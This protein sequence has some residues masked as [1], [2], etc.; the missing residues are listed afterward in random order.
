M[1]KKISDGEMVIR[2]V[3][4]YLRVP[5]GAH[6][7]KPL[8]LL[9]FQKRFIREI[10]D[11][12]HGTRR[13]YMCI[14]RKN[15]KSALTAAIMLAH[16]IGPRAI[17]NSQIVCGAMSRDQA[18]LI[19]NLAVKMLRL[20]PELEGL[21]HVIPSKK[22]IIGMA[23]NV[24]FKALAS[25][26]TTAHGLSPVLAILDEVGQI[27][28]PSSPFVEAITTSQGAHAEPLLIA[29]STSAP[30]DG[31]MWSMW[32][33]DAERSS[34]PH[35]VAHVYKAAEGCDLMDEA[36]WRA[37][38]PALGTFLSEE[39]V[40]QTLSRAQRLPSEEASQ[41]N[42]LLN[43]RISMDRLAFSPSAWKA[44]AMPT[45]PEVFRGRTVYMGLDLSA[46]NDLTAAVLA[47]E[48]DD[49]V[50]QLL[51]IVFCP[52]SG[53]DDRGQRDR[54]PYR[55]WVDQGYLIPVGSATMDY[56][57][58]AQAIGDYL[59]REEIVVEEV[60]Y[61]KALITHFQAAC[62]RASVLQEARWIGVPQFFKEVGI[63]LASLQGLVL[64]K[65][66][67]HGGHPLLNY[68]VANAVAVQGR[69]GI[70]AL[71][72][73]KST[74]RI[75]PLAAAVFAAWPLGEGRAGAQFDVMAMI[76]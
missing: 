16:L 40:R 62:Q 51:P 71:D 1:A 48:D 29:L 17:H 55:M 13:A 61:D 20:N 68:A 39:F 60:H 56:D 57:Q 8:K 27:V 21:A 3:E 53:I 73:K 47:C 23:R 67:A 7:G 46:K 66:V 37:A 75:D 54:A 59:W 28:G 6:V 2:F 42:L 34:D 19:W 15:G 35:T 14:A 32:L 49:G 41:R 72:K 58:I 10:Y 18:S 43:Q 36:Q 12:P 45:G 52:T 50:I 38:N 65:R 69:E 44:C 25:D 24:E 33:D 30:S 31:D 74:A 5:E 63:R 70:S 9:P 64:D 76:G 26:G 11:N 4:E 22:M